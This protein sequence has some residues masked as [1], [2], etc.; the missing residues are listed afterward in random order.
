MSAKEQ[1]IKIIE[2]MSGKYSAY[3][4]FRE[5][6]EC[7]ALAIQNSCS[8]FHDKLW[9]SREEQ[10]LNIM[11]KYDEDE[12][13][14]FTELLYLLTE[15]FEEKIEDVLGEVY[16]KSGCYSKQLGQFFT[17]YHLACLMAQTQFQH[18]HFNENDV[19]EINEP[20]TG[21]GANIIAVCEVIKNT[22]VNYQKILRV[23]AQDL[24]WLAVYMSYV[25]FS[26]LGINAEVVQ[27]D[28]L[29][30]PYIKGNYPHERVFM[31]PMRMGVII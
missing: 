26:L 18:T 15:A 24:D 11:K 16:M 27:G 23:I 3:S 4:I 12:R 22:G 14:L 2:S 8:L 28:T 19:I 1:M 9:Q 20:S 29:L 10:Y 21:G 7:S 6:V 17:P 31:T 25:Q 30:E 5:W 13:H